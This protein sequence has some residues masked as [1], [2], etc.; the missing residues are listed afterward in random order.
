MKWGCGESG[1]WCPASLC[2][3]AQWVHRWVL[4]SQVTTPLLMPIHSKIPGG[5]SWIPRIHIEFARCSMIPPFSV[6]S[7][8][9]KCY[10]IYFIPKHL[11]KVTKSTCEINPLVT[12]CIWGSYHHQTVMNGIEMRSRSWWTSGTEASPPALLP[13]R[14]ILGV[15]EP[16][17]LWLSVPTLYISCMFLF[18]IHTS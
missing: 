7:V 5:F 3:V 8:E 18:Q 17:L 13:F 12:L 10:L 6:C 9:H 14:R 2:K 4:W 16:W 11:I 1:I 15:T